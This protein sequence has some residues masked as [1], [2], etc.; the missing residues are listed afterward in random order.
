MEQIDYFCLTAL[1]N[2]HTEIHHAIKALKEGNKNESKQKIRLAIE[3]AV[4]A[5][6]NL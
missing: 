5:L 1:K 6:A 3:Q 4:S 2:S